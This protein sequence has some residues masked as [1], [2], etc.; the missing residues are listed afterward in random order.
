MPE[1][2]GRYSTSRNV[3][4]HENWVATH[5]I[6]I[7]LSVGLLFVFVSFYRGI[8]VVFRRKERIQALDNDNVTFVFC[9]GKFEFGL[10]I[11]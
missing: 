6:R 7:H 10:I 3:E 8:Q 5:S 11:L 2:D 4:Y 9:N 1:S